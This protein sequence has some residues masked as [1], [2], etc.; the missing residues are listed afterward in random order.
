M[1]ALDKQ[2]FCQV[3]S[4][5]ATGITVVTVLAADG[6]PHGM[7]ANSFTSV[8]LV[9]PL[10]LVC[11]D[12]QSRVLDYLRTGRFFGINVLN[13]NQQAISAHFARSGHDRFFGIE[14]TA[15]QTG[16]PLLPDC[17]AYF[18]CSPSQV[19]EAGDH[20]ILIGEVLTAECHEG[21]PLLYFGSAYRSL[22]L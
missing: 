10:I 14:W 5:F 4:K 21:R 19:V 3:C 16:V 22:A 13:E 2:N 11:V 18:E 15:G 7:T 1:A 9:P 6:T 17:L 12:H 20:A 8:S